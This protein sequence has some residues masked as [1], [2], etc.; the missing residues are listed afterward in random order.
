MI[1]SELLTFSLLSIWWRLIQDRHAFPDSSLLL[2]IWLMD[3]YMSREITFPKCSLG[4]LAKL[5]YH[6]KEAPSPRLMV[7]RFL[8]YHE[9]GQGHIGVPWIT[10]C[11]TTTYLVTLGR[12]TPSQNLARQS[13]KSAQSM[14]LPIASTFSIVLSF[15]ASVY[16]L[17]VMILLGWVKYF[18]KLCQ[19]FQAIG[20]PWWINITLSVSKSVAQ[21][22]TLRQKYPRGQNV[23]QWQSAY[24]RGH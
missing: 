15:W 23:P 6:Q 12:L 5:R 10:E 2:A 21:A 7:G 20:H 4:P 18:D 14:F 16:C 11:P 24:L 3:C 17:V 8:K 13:R 22:D 19:F 9:S 1:I